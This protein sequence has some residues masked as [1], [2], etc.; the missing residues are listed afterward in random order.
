MIHHST[1][2]RRISFDPTG[3]GQTRNAKG[4]KRVTLSRLT[5]RPGVKRDAKSRF[6]PPC[7]LFSLACALF[8]FYLR[9]ALERPPPPN[10]WALGALPRHPLGVRDA[11]GTKGKRAKAT[12]F[13]P[14]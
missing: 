11:A 6:V 14:I 9:P 3:G 7:G 13:D 1:W 5:P 10:P 2:L 4:V 8:R 12:D